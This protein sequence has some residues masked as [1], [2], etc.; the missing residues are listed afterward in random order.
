MNR[1][2][3]RVIVGLA[4]LGLVSVAAFTASQNGVII[5]DDGRTVMVKARAQQAAATDQSDAAL[6]KIYDNLG[7]A[8][9][10]GIYWCCQGAT[11][12]GPDSP[13]N[14]E[15]W[16]GVAF[17]PK[18]NY[19]VTK[20]KLALG[21]LGGTNE[22]VVSLHNDANGVPGTAIKSWKVK[23]LVDGGTCCTVAAIIDQSGIAVTE[24]VQYWI[25]VTT[26]NSDK[27]AFL[28][29]N[30][31]DTDQIDPVPSAARC[32][33]T[34]GQCRQNNGKWVAVPQTPGLALAVLGQ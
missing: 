3:E 5:S 22:L 2:L 20:I 21:Y 13:G 6:V 16:D 14:V 27:D 31:N 9:P 11:I 26:N 17:T 7:T 1:T 10:K 24:G 4:L 32:Y 12:S 28:F 30:V 23:N 15:W 29:W 33:A 18:A 34:G 8:Y 25:T 19:A